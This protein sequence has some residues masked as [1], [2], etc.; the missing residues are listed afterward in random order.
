MLKLGTERLNLSLPKVSVESVTL[1]FFAV[2]SLLGILY[3]EMWRDELQAWMLARD[4]VSLGDLYQNMQY[5]GHPGLWH[6]WLYG[7]SQITHNPL[8]MQLFHWLI[9]I[10]VVYVFIYFSPFPIWQK[11]LFPFG[12]FTFFE[13]AILSRNYSLGVLFIFLFCHLFTRKPRPY[14]PLGLMLALMANVNAYAFII[15][16]ILSLLLFFD[17][18][19]NYQVGPQ[20]TKILIWLS[21]LLIILCGWAISL[22][23][24]IRPLLGGPVGPVSRV[25]SIEP[26]PTPFI[27]E[28]L[29]RFGSVL[30]AIWKSYVP[31][32]AFFKV[33]FWQ[34]N[35][36]ME[37]PV[38]PYVSG[39]SAGEIIAA[40]ASLLLIFFA[41]RLFKHNLAILA[42]YLLGTSAI[43][44][45]IFLFHGSATFRHHGHLYILFIACLWLLSTD[46]PCLRKIRS[47]QTDL[48]KIYRSRFISTILALH[49]I[50]GVYAVSMDIKYPFSTSL[51]AA[52]YIRKNDL[53]EI[54]IFGSRYREVSTISGYLDKQIYYPELQRFG[55]F[56]TNGVPDISPE[57][58]AKEIEG[59]AKTKQQDSVLVVLNK[60]I[61]AMNLSQVNLIELAHFDNSIVDEETFYLYLAKSPN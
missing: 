33:D 20:K 58:L 1:L 35:I 13:Y 21:S 11:I 47:Q 16:F 40:I 26:E 19:R 37:N 7:L 53:K 6:L 49:M 29:K 42:V 48:N 31:I 60:P 15:S 28:V 41:A 4:S 3:H 39:V 34:Q 54:P 38:L 8:A 59:F 46:P 18:F 51:E 52:R 22:S 10:A 43:L 50:A 2:F 30:S 17:A 12:Y 27:L 24:I 23:Q 9:A 25:S 61:Q 32:P 36:L 45:F 5:E 57:E 55:T 44:A 56:W 14:I